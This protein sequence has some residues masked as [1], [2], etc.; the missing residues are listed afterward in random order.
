MHS[1]S[2]AK[3]ADMPDV[4]LLIPDGDAAN[5][6]VSVVVPALNEELTI[7]DFVDWCKEGLRKADVAGE[8]LIV[9]SSTDRTAEIAHS[10]GARVL[11]TPK[12]GLGRAYIDAIPHIRGRLVI[13]GD[14]DCTYDFRELGPFIEQYRKGNEYIMGSRFKGTIEPDAMPALHRYF[15]TPVTTY[16]LNAI[17]GTHFS[18]IHCGMRAVTLSALKR[19]RLQSQGW[20]YASELVLKAAK[21]KLKMA[22]VPIKFY[23][24]PPGRMSLHKRIGW[25]SPWLAG[26]DNLRIMF[27]LSPEFFL[28]KPGLVLMIIGLLLASAL[29]SGPFFV[30]SIGFSLHGMF[31]GVTLAT[32]GYSAFQLGLL[33]RIYHNFDPVFS[34]RIKRILTYNRGTIVGI[35]LMFAGI[36][37]NIPLFV[38]WVKSGFEL[39]MFHNY[40]LFGLLLIILGFQTFVF[41][42]IFEIMAKGYKHSEPPS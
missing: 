23:K 40:A 26:W 29:I 25:I 41:T 18:D 1:S 9:D 10:K 37:L 30:G 5:P 15:G 20:E 12:R 8:I 35:L 38:T 13:M 28:L 36:L 22:E 3:E 16:I 33:S 21:L 24:D 19:I 2:S 34:D 4:K 39:F 31:L 6:E 32:T 17:Y 27:V 7:A 14:C 11:R 42:L